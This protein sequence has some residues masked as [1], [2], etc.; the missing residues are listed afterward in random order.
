MTPDLASRLS[1]AIA[2]TRHAHRREAEGAPI[3]VFSMAK[4]GSSALAAGLRAAKAGPVYHVH[5]LDQG[6]LACEEAEYRWSGRPWRIWDARRLLRR[7]PTPEAPWRVVSVVRDP[8]AQTVS[9]FFQPGVRRGYVH[10]S[11]TVELLRERFGDRLD[12]LPL[13][14]FD[15]HVRPAL[16]IDV[17]ATQSEPEQRYQIISTPLVR[18]LLLRFEDLVVAPV[19]LAQL[20]GVPDPID[21]P[22]VNVAA[23]K[24]YADLYES[25][26]RSLHPTSTQLDRAYGSQLVRRFYTADE[27]GRFRAIWTGAAPDPSASA[28][29]GDQVAR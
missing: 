17:Y 27:I 12:H 10:P 22:R 2:R 25:F 7:P 18:L 6:L 20:L 8:I 26:R 29:T 19:A 24:I 13:R 5:D 16:G 1:Y 4:T 11:A 14:W 15:S 23:E 3:V 9:A 21:V 28:P